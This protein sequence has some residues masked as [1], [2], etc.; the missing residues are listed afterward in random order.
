M[1]FIVSYCISYFVAKHSGFLYFILSPHSKDF[2]LLL[3]CFV[4]CKDTSV[5]SVELFASSDVLGFKD[6]NWLCSKHLYLVKL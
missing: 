6:T 1:F 2:S 3:S 5:R 4:F